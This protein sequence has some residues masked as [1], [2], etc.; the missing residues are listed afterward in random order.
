V[1]VRVLTVLMP[2]SGSEL[3]RLC[4]FACDGSDADQRIGSGGV[5][6]RVQGRIT[7]LSVDRSQRDGVVIAVRVLASMAIGGSESAEW[8]DTRVRVSSLMAI[9]GSELD[10]VYEACIRVCPIPMIGSDFREYV[11]PA[12]LGSDSF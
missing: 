1:C 4:A 8:C 7:C 12:C 10:G 9:S 3:V 5:V 2:I 11:W 6:T